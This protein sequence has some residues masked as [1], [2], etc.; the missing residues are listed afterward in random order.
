M[1]SSPSSQQRTGR[2]YYILKERRIIKH[3]AV[4][5]EEVLRKWDK[6][7]K[8]KTKLKKKAFLKIVKEIFRCGK[9]L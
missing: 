1:V 3:F 8:I 7:R 5:A 9:E 2:M 4:I 6:A